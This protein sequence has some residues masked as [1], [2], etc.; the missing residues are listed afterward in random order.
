[1]I[2]AGFAHFLDLRAELLVAK[3][4][5]AVTELVPERPKALSFLCESALTGLRTSLEV[6]DVVDVTAWVEDASAEHPSADVDAVLSALFTVVEAEVGGSREHD[7]HPGDFLEL[8]RAEAFFVLSASKM[9]R[10]RRRQSDGATRR[11]AVNALLVMLAAR[12]KET[13]AHSQAVAVWSRRIAEGMGLDP[14]TTSFVEMCGL[15]HDIGKVAVP[16]AVL[17]KEGALT[18]DEW[19]AMQEHPGKGAEILAEIPALREYAAAV[20]GHHERYDGH[21]YPDR[22]AG[23]RIPLA[24]RIVAVADSFHAMVS[25]R[26]YRDSVAPKAALEILRDGA[27]TQWDPEAIASMLGLFGAASA[28]SVRTERRIKSA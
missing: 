11:N 5:L 3:M 4:R 8:A 1:M 17:F 20:R 21:G 15:L 18:N 23:E 25:K 14:E 26:C 27:G 12:D 10:D 28:E 22:T 13:A 7:A 6:G 19:A 24:A 9:E 2:Y 16:D